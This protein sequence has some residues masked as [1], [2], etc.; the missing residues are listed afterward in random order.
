M[1][2]NEKPN[3]SENEIVQL[4]KKIQKII[5]KDNTTQQ[6]YL[7]IFTIINNLIKILTIDNNIELFLSQT[8]KQIKQMSNFLKDSVFTV[9]L[10]QDSVIELVDA[11]KVKILENS[12][13]SEEIKTQTLLTFFKI[14][15][16]FKMLEVYLHFI[17]EYNKHNINLD[18]VIFI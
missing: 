17:E 3:K 18:L 12:E 8:N 7:T 10:I 5:A 15:K 2:K 9:F 16:C 11:I 14:A 4:M 13:V 1:L 6:K